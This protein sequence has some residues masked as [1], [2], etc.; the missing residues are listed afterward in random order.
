MGYASLWMEGDC[1]RSDLVP[2]RRSHD[3]LQLVLR[4]VWRALCALPGFGWSPGLLSG[5]FAHK[6]YYVVLQ[7]ILD[8]YYR[9]CKRSLLALS[10]P[11]LL[12]QRRATWAR[13]LRLEQAP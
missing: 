12:W 3:V 5:A 8:S 9:I 6:I 4:S 10:S 13:R 2:H 11:P 1:V 7:C